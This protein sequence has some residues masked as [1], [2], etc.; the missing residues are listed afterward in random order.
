M[1]TRCRIDFVEKWTDNKGKAHEHRRSI[2]R[3]S[4]GYPDG[5]LPDLKEFITWNRGRNGDL[6]Y[7]TANF[8]Y[9]SKRKMEEWLSRENNF[10]WD[11][12]ETQSDGNSWMKI[13]FGVC[14]PKC[15]HGDLE[16]YYEVSLEKGGITIKCFE[17]TLA[18][19]RER[20]NSKKPIKTEKVKI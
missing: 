8:I 11:S 17:M 14:D 7:M 9:W 16:Y 4:D 13:G 12:E 18:N 5:V 19:G 15:W 20:P 2:Y 3:H 6:E 10:K 1:S